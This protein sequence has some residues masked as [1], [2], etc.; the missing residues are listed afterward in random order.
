MVKMR[1]TKRNMRKQEGKEDLL[2]FQL[3]ESDSRAKGDSVT[4][5]GKKSSGNANRRRRETRLLN[6]RKEKKEEAF[7]TMH[8]W[9]GSRPHH[10][11]C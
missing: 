6:K 1:K 2:S 4:R 5:D 7:Y 11:R 8:Q 10:Y 9:L 3:V